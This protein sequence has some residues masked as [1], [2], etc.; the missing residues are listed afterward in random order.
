VAIAIA[1]PL[2]AVVADRYRRNRVMATVDLIRAA[3]LVASALAVAQDAGVVALIAL[4][5]LV[6]VVGTASASARAALIPALART[7]DEL[8]AANVVA[9]TN[10]NLATIVGPALAGVVLA[11]SGATTALLVVAA[12][13]IFSALIVIGVREPRDETTVEG[14]PSPPSFFSRE[15]LAGFDVILRDRPTRLLVLLYSAQT[16]VGGIIGVLVI[17]AASDV[18]SL[19]QSGVGFLFA[20]GGVG[21]LLG[22]VAALG[23]RG[24]RLGTGMAFGIVAWAVPLALIGVWPVAAAALVFFA[25]SSAADAVADVAGVTLLQR[26]I[27]NEFFGRASGAF[28]TVLLGSITLGNLVAPFLADV[29]GIR[30]AI[31]VAGVA[32]PAAAVVWWRPLRRLDAAARARGRE[33]SSARSRS[34]ATFPGRRPSAP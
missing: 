24:Q 10:E 16:F 20:A 15:A 7:P 3:L 26:L 25:V 19:E 29:I 4:S 33:T 32:M 28:T 9:N 34:C 21:G 2:G 1:G 12:T 22:A 8:T 11:V 13:S 23:L 18:L 17:A 30:A 14:A 5:T 6:T 31:V 27:P